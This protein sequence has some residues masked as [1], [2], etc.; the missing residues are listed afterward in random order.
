MRLIGG[1]FISTFKIFPF[2]GRMAWVI[3]FLACLALPPALSPST[4]NSSVPSLSEIEQS[5]SLP[6]SISFFNGVFLRVSFFS[7]VFILSSALIRRFS[8]NNSVLDLSF[9]NQFSKRSF[10]ILSTFFCTSKFDSL[11]FVWPTNWGCSTKTDIE[12]DKIS[13]TSSLLIAKNFLSPISSTYDLNPLAIA[14]RKPVWWVPP[15]LVGIVLQN[16]LITGL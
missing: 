16:D 2:K 8:I 15:S 3:L 11:S 7:L 4:R 12:Q 13:S 5:A 10:I 1:L 14:F 6:G 9:A